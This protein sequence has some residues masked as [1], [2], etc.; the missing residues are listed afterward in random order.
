MF[1]LSPFTCTGSEGILKIIN[2]S[3]F[4]RSDTLHLHLN[5]TLSS[6]TVVHVT[7]VIWI[8]KLLFSPYLFIFYFTFFLANNRFALIL[9]LQLFAP[10]CM[11]VCIPAVFLSWSVFLGG[12][13]ENMWPNTRWMSNQSTFATSVEWSVLMSQRHTAKSSNPSVFINFTALD[14]ISHNIFLSFA[15]IPL[16]EM[17]TLAGSNN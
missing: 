3:F 13:F 9:I 7:D 8:A 15:V 12:F 4:H 10:D 5:S 11:W 17:T 2:Q 1:L 16:A 14:K 6:I